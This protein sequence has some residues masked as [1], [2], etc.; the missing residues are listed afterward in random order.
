MIVDMGAV[1]MVVGVG[2]T[3]GDDCSACVSRK[4]AMPAARAEGGPYGG[5]KRLPSGKGL[6]TTFVCSFTN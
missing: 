2:H 5:G 6:T 1:A 4:T 3:N